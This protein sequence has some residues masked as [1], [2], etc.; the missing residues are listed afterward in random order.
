MEDPT[1]AGPDRTGGGS[2]F[3]FLGGGVLIRVYCPIN[4]LGE[5][6][7]AI[8]LT[9]LVL[10]DEIILWAPA[11]TWLDEC[12]YNRKTSP[13]NAEMLGMLV[14]KGHVRIAAREEYILNKEYRNARDRWA[15]QRWHE[16]HQRKQQ[17]FD[18]LIKRIYEF[19]KKTNAHTPRVFT[20]PIGERGEERGYK[21][22]DAQISAGSEAFKLAEKLY[23]ADTM[24]VATRERIG[25]N[26]AFLKSRWSPDIRR[27]LESRSMSRPRWWRPRKD[28]IER[29]ISEP[30]T[31]TVREI[32]RDARNNEDFRSSV[33]AD[34]ILRWSPYPAYEFDQIAGRPPSAQKRIDFNRQDVRETLRWIAK[35]E[36]ASNIDVLLKL[37][38]DAAPHR[39]LMMDMLKSPIHPL[40]ELKSQ[41]ETGLN[42]KGYFE[43]AFGYWPIAAACGLASILFAALGVKASLEVDRRQFLKRIG[44]GIG[45][46]AGGVVMPPSIAL[47]Y[48][49]AKV[50]GLVPDDAYEGPVWLNLLAFGTEE[51]Y[52][53]RI[54]GLLDQ[55]IE[56]L[57]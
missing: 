1:R 6:G 12:Y 16:P 10:A 21:W 34:W 46:A 18:D 26:V 33:N 28:D 25:R 4:D 30:E 5:Y 53:D 40:A 17:N 57:E 48:Q 56:A 39:E 38:E 13:I 51:A 14:K 20:F 35:L 50:E 3:A 23:V 55:I 52:R 42:K 47:G 15:G 7:W 9:Q 49:E 8:Y 2:G 27:R 44:K 43:G 36:E 29:W 32:L 11:A 19:D 54:L 22:A 45:Y 24:P 41:I 37:R 31:M